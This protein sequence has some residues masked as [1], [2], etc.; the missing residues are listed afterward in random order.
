MIIENLS[1]TF[2]WF[3][4]G[5]LFLVFEI[6]TFGVILLF[7]GLG[8]WV[9]AIASWLFDISLNTQLLLFISTSLLSLLTLR[10]FLQRTFIGQRSNNQ[11]LQQNN[12]F[13]GKKARVIQAISLDNAG[14]VE[15]HGSHWNAESS[16]SL[17]EN[18]IVEITD[19]QSTILTVKS[20]SH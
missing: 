15:F 5:L 16:E 11:E 6:S 8:A 19:I 2:I 14:K 1:P 3:L 4:I 18:Q 10:R 20:L 12:E 13:I 17:A 9:T 7:F